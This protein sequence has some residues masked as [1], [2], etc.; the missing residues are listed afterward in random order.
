MDLLLYLPSSAISYLLLGLVFIS[1]LLFL[2]AINKTQYIIYFL[3]LWFPFESLIL[4]YTPIAYF[5]YVKYAPEAILYL[6]GIGAL[7]HYWRTKKI[8]FPRTPLN[9]WFAL[10]LI[11]ALISLILNQ[12][13]PFIWA[14][15]LRQTLRF[16]LVLFIVLFLNYPSKIIKNF[17]ILGGAMIA[18]EAILGLIQYAFG[19][20]L[21]RYLFPSRIVSI[22]KFALLGGEEAFW[23]PGSRVFAT[24]GRYDQLGSFLSLGLIMLFPWLYYLK[25]PTEKFWW[26]AGM[27]IGGL[28]LIL[29]MSRASWIA[30]FI[31]IIVIGV[32]H[33]RDKRIYR[34]LGVFFVGLIIYLSGFALTHSNV[35][36]LTERPNQSLAERILEAGSLGA[37]RASYDGYGRIFFIINTPLTVVASAPFFGVGPGNYGG[38]A[39]AALVNTAVYDRLQLPF[40][41]GGVF[42]QIDN[43][44]L[45]I[46]GEVGTLGLLAWA[47]I[48]LT[49]YKTGKQAAGSGSSASSDQAVAEGVMGLATGIMVI[50]FFGPYFEFRSLSFYFWLAGGVV[51]LAY[52]ENLKLGN[53]LK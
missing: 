14:L 40:G 2:F 8:L 52:Q 32:I 35:L 37:W 53:F 28:A 15:G 47:M 12:Y 43:N 26:A 16:S 27:L 34:A 45:S 36:S 49:I 33:R 42:G 13:D 10:Y 5:V 20:A 18:T 44:W 29:T 46:W 6:F 7:I 4:N 3:L 25:K 30:A 24:M 50:G 21:D 1:S 17:L 31:G 38:G 48:L 51:I 39:A 19:G 41:I 11:V 22:G 23:V 9:K